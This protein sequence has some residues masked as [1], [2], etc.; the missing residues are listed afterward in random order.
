MIASHSR[1]KA[2][3][4]RSREEGTQPTSC[5]V[6]SMSFVSMSSSYPWGLH[7]FVSLPVPGHS[8][9][10]IPAGFTLAVLS[11]LLSFLKV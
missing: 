5:T 8:S 1:S 3:Q 2:F 9:S 4:T 11:L 7:P 10:F 6:E